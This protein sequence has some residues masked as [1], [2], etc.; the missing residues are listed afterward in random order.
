MSLY[1][2]I[3]YNTLLNICHA[4][5]ALFIYEFLDSLDLDYLYPSS[6]IRCNHPSLSIFHI[7]MCV[8][9]VNSFCTGIHYPTPPDAVADTNKLIRD[10]NLAMNTWS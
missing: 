8:F 9:L 5:P 4:Q 1:T 2:F 7:F 6:L 10:V 3:I